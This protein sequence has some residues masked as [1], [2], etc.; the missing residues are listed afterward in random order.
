MAFM[1]NI[2][3]IFEFFS[4]RF[5]VGFV[6]FRKCAQEFHASAVS[7][8]G[9]FVQCC[10]AMLKMLKYRLLVHTSS[11]SKEKQ[12]AVH[13]FGSLIERLSPEMRRISMAASSPAVAASC[14]GVDLESQCN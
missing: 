6:D 13:T 1:F 10:V 5:M 3:N 12:L 11:Q 8:P 14:N 4:D 2:F 9:G 7:T